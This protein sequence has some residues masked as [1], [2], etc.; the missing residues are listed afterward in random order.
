[1]RGKQPPQLYHLLLGLFLLKYI[2]K[3]HSYSIFYSW[4]AEPY[5]LAF[6]MRGANLSFV[7]LWCIL[8]YL[9]YWLLAFG[10]NEIFAT[11]L[12]VFLL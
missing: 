11:L 2:H 6:I 8:I 10:S 7:T 1:L 12:G 9:F 4:L 5:E 3:L